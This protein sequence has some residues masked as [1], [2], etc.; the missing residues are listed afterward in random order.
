MGML[1]HLGESCNQTRHCLNAEWSRSIQFGSVPS[2]KKKKRSKIFSFGADTDTEY[3]V[4]S[5]TK[6][7]FLGLTNQDIG[8]SKR[9]LIKFHTSDMF[10]CCSLSTFRH[11]LSKNTPL[12]KLFLNFSVLHNDFGL[13]QICFSSEALVLSSRTFYHA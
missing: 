13:W 5:Q 10:T 6:R 12:E 2:G 1:N 8:L 3:H 7:L 11:W 4:G 9:I